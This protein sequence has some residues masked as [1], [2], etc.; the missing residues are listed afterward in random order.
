MM[1]GRLSSLR[2]TGSARVVWVGCDG[3]DGIT[4]SYISEDRI[5]KGFSSTWSDCGGEQRVWIAP[6]FGTFRLFIT[7]GGREMDT[8]VV[9]VPLN[10]LR[11]CVVQRPDDHKWATFSARMTPVIGF[12]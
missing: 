6:E 1:A 12:S 11:L 8:Y 7:K 4:Q 3:I 9:S 2:R 5:G 10:T